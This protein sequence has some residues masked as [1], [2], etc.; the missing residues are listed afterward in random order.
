MLTTLHGSFPSATFGQGT[1]G[2]R[3]DEVTAEPGDGLPQA[4]CSKQYIMQTDSLWCSSW[5]CRSSQ[6]HYIDSDLYCRHPVLGCLGFCSGTFEDAARAVRCCV[7]VDLE[8]LPSRHECFFILPDTAGQVYDNSRA[9]Q[10]LQWEPVDAL[11]EYWTRNTQQTSFV[12]AR[13]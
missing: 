9:K 6:F 12:G 5:Q 4:I 3:A 13:L 2:M 10:L 1:E 7:E 8:A 11:A